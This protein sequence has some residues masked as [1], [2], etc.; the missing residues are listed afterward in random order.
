MAQAKFSLAERHIEF[1]NQFE[2]YGFSDKSALV[3]E[4]LDAMKSK[5]TQERLAESARLYAEVYSE[6][7]EL[8]E[9][10]EAALED[11][12]L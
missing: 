12:P 10:T 3:R 1:V 4:A 11:W 5:L 6:D 9:L 2:H 8:R 7:E